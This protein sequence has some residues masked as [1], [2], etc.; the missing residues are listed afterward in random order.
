MKDLASCWD[1]IDKML[2]IQLGEIHASFRRSRTVFEDKYK[3]NFWYSELEGY[4]YRPALFLSLGRQND[5]RH[6]VLLRKIAVVRKRHC[7]GCHVHVL[8]P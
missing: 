2:A 1:E 5:P 4:V 8:M 7:M 3:D 6:P